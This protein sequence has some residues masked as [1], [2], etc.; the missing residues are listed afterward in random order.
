MLPPWP[1]NTLMHFSSLANTLNIPTF[2][3]H[4]AM[5]FLQELTFPKITRVYFLKQAPGGGLWLTGL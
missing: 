5:P 4:V 3:P 2:S 1:I